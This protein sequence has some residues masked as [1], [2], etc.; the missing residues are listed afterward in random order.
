MMMLF[1]LIIV[2][3]NHVRALLPEN[4]EKAV[5]DATQPV[6]DEYGKR[7]NTSFQIGLT[8]DGGQKF[9]M[10]S[11]IDDHSSDPPTL[12]KQ[13]TLIPMGSATKIY[14]AVAIMQLYERGIIDIDRPVHEI[15]DPFLNRTNGTTLLEL[16][17]E[18]KTINQVTT[19]EL[20]GM[21]GCLS[22]YDDGKLQSFVLNPS[23][24]GVTIDPYDYL[25]VWAQ[26]SFL[27]EPGS[28]GAY[29]S[30]G[31]V[32]LGFVAASATNATTW[33]DFD[34][35]SIFPDALRDELDSL[36]FSLG[37]RCSDEVEQNVSHQYAATFSSH[38]NYWTT[39]H[40]EDI[41]NFDC[42][43]GWYVLFL[44]LFFYKTYHYYYCCW[45]SYTSRNSQ[46]NGQHR[47][48]SVRHI[49]SI[50]SSV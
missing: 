22:D 14:T 6:L 18:D 4:F 33:K 26:K 47:S 15:V 30:I 41:Y 17:G 9:E 21:R 11:G 12:L 28:G 24:A 23:N 8:F 48:K 36:I 1:L 25:H 46:D 31:F 34:Q 39:I 29:S 43:N 50:V 3:V 13:N 2:V 37:G 10:F 7:F 38:N 40:W 16:W 49:Y 32:I 35:K 42:L 27:C 5:R 19:R 44:R 45:N 20:M